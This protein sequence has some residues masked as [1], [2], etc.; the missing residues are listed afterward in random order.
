MQISECRPCPLG[1]YAPNK[2]TAICVSCGANTSLLIPSIPYRCFS[3]TLESGTESQDACYC[4]T[5]EAN[6]VVET[7]RFELS[8]GFRLSGKTPTGFLICERCLEYEWCSPGDFTSFWTVDQ[9]C[10]SQN[11]AAEPYGTPELC[12][13]YDPNSPLR[14][15]QGKCNLLDQCPTFEAI[16]DQRPSCIDP[17]RGIKC[18]EVG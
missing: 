13:A 14:Y 1:F 17:Y 3:A 18:R 9:Y 4:S 10:S 16:Q 5:G 6:A 11:S 8:L 15:L 12:S 7:S 2:A